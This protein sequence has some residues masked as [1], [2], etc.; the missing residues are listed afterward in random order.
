M[1]KGDALILELFMNCIPIF[2][3]VKLIVELSAVSAY[4]CVSV[5]FCFM[6]DVLACVL[7][8]LHLPVRNILAH[9]LILIHLRGIRKRHRT[10]VAND[11]GTRPE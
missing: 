8:G 10:E 2:L 11:C 5:R 4:M 3:F 9:F 1:I 7:L 6:C